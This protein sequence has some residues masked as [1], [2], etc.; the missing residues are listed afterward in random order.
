M[1]NFEIIFSSKMLTFKKTLGGPMDL[2][3]LYSLPK[4]CFLNSS[5][6]SLSVLEEFLNL[7]EMI[8]KRGYLHSKRVQKKWNPS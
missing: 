6:Y 2:A 1:A 5:H 8:F 3:E 4:V 7:F